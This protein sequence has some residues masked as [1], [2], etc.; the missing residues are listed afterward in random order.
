M[1]LFFSRKLNFFFSFLVLDFEKKKVQ[2]NK[3]S[4]DDGDNDNAHIIFVYIFVKKKEREI[5]YEH[6]Q[7]ES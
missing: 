1:I 7:E 2:W 3:F 5:V 4:F 6:W